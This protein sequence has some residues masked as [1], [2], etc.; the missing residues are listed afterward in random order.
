MIKEF[1]TQVLDMMELFKL[2]NELDQTSLSQ[3]L[4]D[5]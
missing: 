1:G 5:L 4:I 3:N 2:T